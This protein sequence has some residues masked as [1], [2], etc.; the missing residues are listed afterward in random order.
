MCMC[1]PLGKLSGA[2]TTWGDSGGPANELWGAPNKSR[3]PPPG[4]S[5]KAPTSNGWGSRWGPG[6]QAPASWGSNSTW[7]LL[8]NLTPQ[9]CRLVANNVAVAMNKEL[10]TH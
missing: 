2:K 10:C 9:V 5:S 4:M 6:Q 3:G 1:S 7:L 8:K